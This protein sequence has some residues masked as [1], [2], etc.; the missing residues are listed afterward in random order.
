MNRELSTGRATFAV[1]LA[2]ALAHLAGTSARADEEAA[3]S[4]VT[5][6]ALIEEALANSP[7]IAAARSERGAAA[8]RVAP[9]GALDD[10]ML[11]AGVINAPLDPL[12][13]SRED[14]TMKMLGL[15]QRL[16][17]PGKR[18]L[19]RAVAESDATSIQWAS[20]ETR[21]R[22]VREVRVAYADLAANQQ[23]QLILE[24][25][26][27]ALAQLVAT[28]ESRYRVGKA[29]QAD[30]LEARTELARLA[31]E[32][33]QLLRD[34]SMLQA[35]LRRATGKVGSGS[36]VQTAPLQL[37]ALPVASDA[38]VAQR[39]QLRAL[40]A[41]VQ[42]ESESIS[43][44]EREYYPDFD[45][46]LQYGQ[47]DRAPDGTP[48]DDMVSLTV[49]VNLPIWRKARLEPAVAEARSMR[50][51]AQQMLQAQR[52]QTEADLATRRSEITQWRASV[53]TYRNSLLP[54]ARATVTSAM[55]GY[56]VGAVDFLAL[57]TA[58]TREFELESR[59][60]EAIAAHNKAI[61]E[62][63][64]LTGLPPAMSAMSEV[65]P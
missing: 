61:V 23:K 36:N 31:T 8:S 22:V 53:E 33:Q 64:F 1:V 55:A 45:V 6:Q 58:Q 17:F 15:E 29:M 60:V 11:E 14:M 44:A 50:D 40:E 65:S 37:R 19:R 18:D 26:H 35:E 63:D 43:L 24:R 57:R 13:L 16:P 27:D 38:D 51:R 5:E 28:A 48:R 30:V 32:R 4:L 47:R 49:A 9:A 12:S 46:S 2:I 3:G 52:L 62:I 59:L 10:P 41:L 42:R 39:P 25:T 7:E 21:N 20:E 34:E 56:R 54:Q